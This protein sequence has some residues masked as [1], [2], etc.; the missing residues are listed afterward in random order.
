MNNANKAPKYINEL[1]LKKTKFRLPFHISKLANKLSLVGPTSNQ[2]IDQI[3]ICFCGNLK[4]DP[5][6]DEIF[7]SLGWCKEKQTFNRDLKFEVVKEKLEL[8]YDFKIEQIIPEE[9]PEENFKKYQIS[10]N[11]NNSCSNF[12]I[13][14]N[15]NLSFYN[16]NKNGKII[17]YIYRLI[18]RPI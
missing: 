1:Q 14:N 17:I 12:I 4:Y 2:N 15:S 7:V 16:S 10:S 9:M 8:A 13:N 18:Y 11:N 3:L 5:T 6:L